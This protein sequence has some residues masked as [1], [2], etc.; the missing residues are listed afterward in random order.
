MDF[1]HLLDPCI[2]VCSGNK[3]C[4]NDTYYYYENKK[5]IGLAGI[6]SMNIILG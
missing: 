5:G 3:D 1:W 2:C 4:F 6:L